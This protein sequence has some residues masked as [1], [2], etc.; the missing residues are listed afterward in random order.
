MGASPT[1]PL[2][3]GTPV[4]DEPLMPRVP[5]EPL[6][7]DLTRWRGV[8]VTP[9]Q[10]AEH[11]GLQPKTIREW[12]RQGKIAG[13]WHRRT[14]TNTRGDWMIPKASAIELEREMGLTV[15]HTAA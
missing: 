9:R 4:R 14:P 12:C 1:P 5:P 6:P 13:A 3:L 10:F 11:V 7:A 15:K 8:A 2:P